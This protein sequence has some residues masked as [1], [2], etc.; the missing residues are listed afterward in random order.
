M[1]RWVLPEFTVI[2]VDQADDVVVEL[3]DELAEVWREQLAGY[4]RGTEPRRPRSLSLDVGAGAP[5]RRPSAPD[6]AWPA[7]GDAAGVRLPEAA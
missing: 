2:G 4:L 1:I 7:A 3:V 6:G 5:A